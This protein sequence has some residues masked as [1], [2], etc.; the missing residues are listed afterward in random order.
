MTRAVPDVQ[1]PTV[2]TISDGAVAI[3]APAAEAERPVEAVRRPWIPPDAVMLGVSMFCVIAATNIMTPLLPQIRDDLGI[4]ITTAGIIVGSFGLARLLVDL[5]AGFLASN[6]APRVLSLV[7]VLAL[8]VSSVIGIGANTVET[9][10][11]ARVVSGVGVAILAT[12]ILAALS[13]LASRPTGA[14]S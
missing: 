2:T 12:V 9:L 14:R 5:P 13:A 6:I 10:I 8:V 3:G 11:V 4:S 1:H 7:A